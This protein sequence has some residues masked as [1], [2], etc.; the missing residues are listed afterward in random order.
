[1]QFLR[2]KLSPEISNTDHDPRLENLKSKL[3]TSYELAR[4]HGRKSHA[5][6]KRYYD[7]S[8]REREFA[9][10]DFVYLYNPAIK[11]GVSDKFRRA[12][13]GS[14]RVTEKRSRLNYVLVNQRGK[15]L[16]VHV[17][18]LKRAY[19]PVNW[20]ET[21]KE[22][23]EQR[24]RPKRQQQ[25]GEEDQEMPS[26]GPIQIRAPQVE[27][28]PQ[29][30]RIPVRNRQILVTPTLSPSPRE[31]PSN[32]RPVPTYAPSDTPRSRREL[33]TT[34]ENPPLTRLRSRM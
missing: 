4:K 18:R 28:S 24:V 22:K 17:N 25:G 14:W 13:V 2:A 5:T 33:G 32:R 1:M 20:Q 11:V 31:P 7:R 12:W 16:V 9:V 23:P 3:K 15:Q 19:D 21:R 29:V 27:N 8:A 26:A 30:R 34:R 6:N 10:G